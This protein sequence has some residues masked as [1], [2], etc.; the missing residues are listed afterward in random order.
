LTSVIFS[1]LSLSSSGLLSVM[2][3]L[4]TFLTNFLYAPGFFLPFFFFFFCSSTGFSFS[5][6][7]SVCFFPSIGVEISSFVFFSS[8]GFSSSLISFYSST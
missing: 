4:A 5:F 2:S 7:F 6:I 3:P 8:F 1:S